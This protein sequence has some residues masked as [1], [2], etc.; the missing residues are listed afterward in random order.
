MSVADFPRLYAFS[1]LPCNPAVLLRFVKFFA[2]GFLTIIFHGNY[3][4]IK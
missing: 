3:K 1:V 4:E 2:T